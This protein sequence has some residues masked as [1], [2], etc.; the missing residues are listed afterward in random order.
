M[1]LSTVRNRFH[2]YFLGYVIF[3]CLS[4]SVT[5]ATEIARPEISIHPELAA[6]TPHFEEKVYQIG[7]N[8]F[9]AV[10]YSLGNVIMIVGED[11]VIVVD[12]GTHPGEAA[13][14]W[15]ELRKHSEKPVRAVVYTHFHPDHWGGVKAIVSPEEVASGKVRIFAHETLVSNVIHQGG[16]V[17]PILAMR[18]GY[19]FG[20]GLPPEDREGM[21]EGIGPEVTQGISGFIYPTD[22]FADRL[23]VTIAGVDMEM[24]HVPSE[25]PD[26][27]SVYLKKE[28]ILLSG[29][30]IQGPTLPNIH[31][32]RGTKFRDPLQWY[33]SIDRLRAF[34]A[35]HLVPSH[36]QP[37]YGADRV[38]EVLRLTRD[39]I[40]FIHD[41]TLR[42]M[43]K[44]LTPDELAQTVVFPDYL[45]NSKPY[46]R[47]YYGTV[48]HAVRQ[49][50]TGYLGW[51]EGDPVD[52][53]PLPSVEA[54]HRYVALMGGRD[55]VLA[56][57]RT[58]YE[59]GEVQWA[60]ELATHLVRTNHDDRAARLLKAAAFRHL[61]YASMN[62]NWRNWYLTSARELE[63]D[64]DPVGHLMEFAGYFSSPDIVA[65]WPLARVI[66]GLGPRLA[67]DKTLDLETTLA[68]VATD[69]GEAHALE[70]RRA[71]A[72]FHETIPDRAELT[73]RA[74]R[75]VL[76]GLLTG[77]A[78][79]GQLME[80]GVL[81][82][83]G[84]E[85]RLEELL[86]MFDPL[87]SPIRLT[88]R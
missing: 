24:V 18:S 80:Q 12:T 71:V 75:L 86:G 78:S 11:G 22:V 33:K 52:L 69:T 61:G 53:D 63:G 5:S 60:A 28:K 21:N 15:R 17:G 73:V 6:H 50:Y 29:E 37:I 68:F 19:S 9:S 32:L 84:S 27:I 3:A 56:V 45:A 1:S 85:T 74:P 42:H 41:Q 25:A 46:L 55:K 65:A 47:E 4:A 36:G 59:D 49:I 81:Q 87:F 2:P 82:V 79:V 67:P 38:E 64:I 20:I 58:A 48:K 70:I 14:A 7:G 43:N 13:E 72:Q 44:G 26:E 88:V 34:G 51:F 16:A 77:R 8:V 31:T 39:G 66:E 30:T 62:S 76:V 54:S 35:D 40:Q 10:G 57:A 23:E 83:D